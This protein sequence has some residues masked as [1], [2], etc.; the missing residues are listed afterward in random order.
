MFNFLNLIYL[1]LLLLYFNLITK[2]DHHPFMRVIFNLYKLI[3]L[4]MIIL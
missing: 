2:G 1:T 4:F 3:L